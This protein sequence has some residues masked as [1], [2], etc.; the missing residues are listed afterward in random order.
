MFLTRKCQ[1]QKMLK[2]IDKSDTYNY[3]IPVFFQI[4]RKS[5][6]AYLWYYELFCI[7]LAL[8]YIIIKG[9]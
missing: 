1:I 9:V 3:I 2:N 4:A 8:V 7:I 5:K 6:Q